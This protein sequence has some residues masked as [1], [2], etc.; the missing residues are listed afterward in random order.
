MKEDEPVP[1]ATHLIV[2]VLLVCFAFLAFR[3]LP[4]FLQPGGQ[5]EE[6]Y[7]VPGWAILQT[8]IPHLPHVPARNVE[9]VF[10]RGE[11]CL[12]AEP[13]FYFYCQAILF[14]ILPHTYGTARLTS[15]LAGCLMLGTMI[16][17]MTRCKIPLL[18]ATLITFVFSLSRWFFF[19]AISAR[20]DIMCGALGLLAVDRLMAW[21]KQP[22][23]SRLFVAG[24]LL[25]LSG[26]THVFA[27]AFAVP[28]GI[29]VFLMSPP[30]ARWRPTFQLASYSIAVALAWLP[31]II[32]YRDIFAEQFSNQFLH[33]VGDS[34]FQRLVWPW[35]S[36]MY[37]CRL[38]FEHIG[39]WQSF[40]AILMFF[41]LASFGWLRKDPTLLGLAGVSLATCWFIAALVGPHHPVFGYWSMPVAI[42]FIGG[43]VFM[44]ALHQSVTKWFSAKR[45]HYA[46]SLYAALTLLLVLSMA[47]GSGIRTW[48]THVREMENRIYRAPDFAASILDRLPKD[49]VYAVDTQ[50]A[51]DFLAAGR[52]TLIAESNPMYFRI[53]QHDIDYLVISRHGRELRLTDLF[54]VELLWTDGNVDDVLACYVEVY[55]V[56]GVAR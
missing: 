13:P 16:H 23:Q 52:T 35:D 19:A 41:S 9:S 22:T 2:H 56:H 47:P 20:P 21:Q 54:D 53:D 39:F 38:T 27:I 49:A 5:D 30:G 26:L 18:T 17:I 46:N 15:A 10:F 24:V 25:G 34:A 28:I 50:F 6:Y 36:I 45:A 31:L 33:G 7:A 29:W 43:G 42:A 8:G 40:M 55:R 4:M 3:G 1:N 11:E 37:H 12:F 51:L 14:W 44:D 32:M 48:W